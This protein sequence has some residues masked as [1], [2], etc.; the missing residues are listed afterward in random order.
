MAIIVK[1]EDTPETAIDMSKAIVP[2]VNEKP[3]LVLLREDVREK[4]LAE[5]GAEVDSFEPS[6]ELKKDREAIATFAFKFT[7]S[8]TAIQSAA[9]EFNEDFYAKISA[10]N[11]TRD[12]L[13]EKLDELRNR[14]R[15]P[16]TAWEKDEKERLRIEA[17]KAAAIKAKIDTFKALM[18]VLRSDTS[19]IIAN[20]IDQI[21]G[22][23]AC[24][25]TE[26]VKVEA[27]NVLGEALNRLIKEEADRA[28]LEKLRAEAA[29]LKR[30]AAQ[31]LKDEQDAKRI[32]GEQARASYIAAIDEIGAEDD[33][34]AKFAAQSLTPTDAAKIARDFVRRQDVTTAEYHQAVDKLISA[35]NDKGKA[36][37]IAKSALLKECF[38]LDDASAEEVIDVIVR[39]LIPGVKFEF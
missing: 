36:I 14:A 5:L 32:A 20:R 27:I 29:E 19:E 38:G 1:P 8:K 35:E 18:V 17:E 37:R 21:K 6:L 4:F 16:L 9:K 3:V 11:A 34:R 12:E 39:G 13:A 7:R 25:A 2:Q 30:V 33:E 15:A 22:M 23:D 28:E 24:P 26:H 10:V 31:K